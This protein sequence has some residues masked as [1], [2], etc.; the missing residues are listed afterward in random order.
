[1]L[2]ITLGAYGYQPDQ[3]D[4]FLHETTTGGTPA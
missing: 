3:A 1:M 2:Q 4:D